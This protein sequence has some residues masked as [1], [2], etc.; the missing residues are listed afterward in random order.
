MRLRSGAVSLCVLLAA[1]LLAFPA[2]E[3]TISLNLELSTTGIRLVE[4]TPDGVVLE[5]TLPSLELEELE[6]N[7]ETW[8]RFSFDGSVFSG[9]E[10]QAALPVI[11]RSVAIPDYVGVNV[12]ILDIET[13]ELKGYRLAPVEGVE[14]EPVVVDKAWYAKSITSATPDVAVGD[15]A[16]MRDLR[17]VPVTFR[18]VVYDPVSGVVQV[19][20]RMT[21]A[22]DFSGKNDINASVKNKGMIPE[23]FDSFYKTNV[24]NYDA[25]NKSLPVSLGTY[26]M[27]CP[28][29]STVIANLE[30][31][32]NWRKR[33]GYNVILA[34]TAETGT[35]NTQIKNYIQTQYDTVKPALEFVTLVGDVSGTVAIPAWS[36]SL[37]GYGGSGDH[38][39]TRLEGND[40]LADI[41]LGR[42]SVESTAELTTVVNKIVNYETSPPNTGDTGWFQRAALVG[43]PGTSG[44]TCI[45]VNQWA[46]NQ[47]LHH[48]YT[49][50]DTVWGG[51]FVTEMLN[52]F[53]AGGTL[54]TYRGWYGMSGMS[55]SY[56]M[57]LANADKLGFAVMITCDTGSFASDSNCRSEAFLRAPNGGGVA[58]IGTATIG[59]H[60]RYNNCVFTAVIDH[61]WNSGDYRVGPALTSGK[62]AMYNNYNIGEPDKVEIWSVWNNLMGDPCTEI[63]T[64]FPGEF[65][66]N[67]DTN[68]SLD[69]TNT[70]I[71]VF[72]RGTGLPLQ[73]AFVTVYKDGEIQTTAMTAADGTVNLA[74]DAFTAGDMDLTVR[75]HNFMPAQRKIVL[76]GTTE[77]VGVQTSVIDDTNWGDSDGQLEATEHVELGLQ[78]INQG[79]VTSPG[80][81]AYLSSNDPY[82]TIQSSSVSYG[83]IS[84]GA[85]AW[86]T[87]M[88]E[89]T[90]AA[91]AP[92][93]YDLQLDLAIVSGPDTWHNLVELTVQGPAYSHVSHSFGGSGG[94]MDPGESGTVTVL[95]QNYGNTMGYGTTATLSTDSPWITVTDAGGTF[96]D[97]NHQLTGDNAGDT[98]AIAIDS[99]CYP[100]HLAAFRLDVLTSGGATSVV[101]FTAPVGNVASTDPVGPDSY[102]YYAYDNTDTAYPEAPTFEWVEIDPTLGGSGVSV[103]LNDTGWEG[104]DTNSFAMPFTFTYYGES[105]DT[106]SICSNGWLSMGVAESKQYRN[107]ALPTA[108]AA[109][110]MIAGFWDNLFRSGATGG[111]FTWYDAANHRLIVEWS[112]MRTMWTQ[113]STGPEETFEIILYDPAF[114]PTGSGDG[115]IEVMYNVVN[116][117]DVTNGYATAGLMNLDH[118]DGL[119]YEYW[120]TPAP[121]AASLQSG[122]AIRYLPYLAI[123]QGTLEGTVTNVTAGA[124]AKDVL[125][126]VV[127]GNRSFTSATNGTYQGNVPTG[128]Y[129]VVASHPEF[130]PDTTYAVTISEDQITVVDFDL[131]DIFGPTFANT[132]A[133]S[134]TDDEVGPYTVTSEITDATGIADMHF[135]YM[136]TTD[137]G[138]HELPLILVDA[139]TSRY[140]ADI[141]GQPDGT[142]VIYWLSGTDNAGN[143]S[144]YPAG[145]PAFAYSFMIQSVVTIAA[146]N[147]E[148]ADGWT[149][150]DAGDTASAG[151]W[152][153][154]DPNA[155]FVGADQV[156]PED[157]HTVDPANMCWI[158][159]QDD[160]GGSQGGNDV[161]GGATTLMSPVYDLTGTSSVTV[162]YWRW[163][164]NETGNAPDSD[165]W[166]VQV[167]ADGG[168]WTTLE[169]TMVSD[170]SWTKQ[171]FQLNTL[172]VDPTSVRFRFEASDLGS[173]SVVEAGV[174][175]LTLT[176]YS[177]TGD[178]ESP[179]VAVTYP[180]GGE[181]IVPTGLPLNSA[182]II[183]WT[184]SDNLAVS[185]ALVLL[186]LD[187]GVSYPDTLADGVYSNSAPINWPITSTTTCRIKVVVFDAALNAAE[188]MSDADFELDISTAIGDED[189]PGR[190]ELA[191]NVPNPFNPS[192]D[193]AFALPRDNRVTLKVF[194]VAGR[195]VRTLVNDRLDAGSHRV[196]WHGLNDSGAQVASG[197]YFY[198]LTVGG[199]VGTRKMTLLK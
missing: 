172:L 7:E 197:T 125:V 134:G 186:S 55:S 82:V 187:G 58:S 179:T 149:V 128:V 3:T 47:L 147:M 19:A 80:T 63:W 15:P 177:L 49:Q 158:T 152:E 154:V 136:S 140:S 50:V 40:I 69:A 176:G 111:V 135:W 9:I 51:N 39:Y 56:I 83:D 53:G 22:L 105:F 31:L 181:V 27:I 150:G 188:D 8:Q 85:A 145:S 108:G 12:R 109:D 11:S 199:D 112:R 28:N 23:S 42:L 89:I 192:T 48:G 161:D 119:T 166:Q 46:K 94:S 170:R 65:T 35:S 10:G 70:H 62:L 137:G 16:I 87:G 93:G 20:H 73:N 2:T 32:L 106:I 113:G 100:G 167:S 33:Q 132:T 18:P 14:G 26:L 160:V 193:I 72:D 184:A 25:S 123:A 6:I 116:N 122:R 86:G 59:T 139:P 81:T 107:W 17:V 110:G 21:I 163:Y 41:H 153:R 34:T 75:K 91:D 189:L 164:T 77:F 5:L 144:I 45:F 151:L 180:N 124:P 129:D 178:T 120:N 92:G 24:L 191:R 98:F 130:A 182:D 142:R 29:N 36:E 174:D 95:M 183:T 141:P 126:T 96:G 54:F 1:M 84:S 61:T 67:Y 90:V 118:T 60:T 88:F 198:R 162:S 68:L 30:P 102:G 143:P 13:V 43:D 133:L 165:T 37:S 76:G 114:H 138:P 155:I 74:L 157:D 156:T 44:I 175:D 159:G 169:S 195:E 196:T 78:L 52:K 71:T 127:N 117:G 168:G 4:S 104:D 148:A 97:I 185:R 57:N 66:V 79:T 190:L 101:E 121:G 131:I 171:T 64:G 173:G 99:D 103:G 194:D 38:D 146:D 115:M